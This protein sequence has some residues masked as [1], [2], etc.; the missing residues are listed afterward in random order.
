MPL[1]EVPKRLAKSRH[2]EVDESAKLDRHHVPGQVDEMHRYRVDLELLQ[3][4]SEF[5]VAHGLATSCSSSI[6]AP[7]PS[8]AASAAASGEDTSNRGAPVRV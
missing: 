2:G 7:T 1:S 4:E 8:M 5:P 6:V 3:D